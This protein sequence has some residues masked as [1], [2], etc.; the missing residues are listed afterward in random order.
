MRRSCKTIGGKGNVVILMGELSNEAA[1]KRTEGTKQVM[2][3]NPGIK[4]IR[5]Q[6]GNW[7]AR[8]GKTIMENWLASGDKI[9]AVAS[10]ND[11]MALGAVMVIKAAGKLGKIYV[12]GID[13]SPDALDVHG[14]GRAQHDRV[15]GPG[16]PG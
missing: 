16:R 11:E 14:Q 7:P 12:S 4:V 5:E 2:A 6:T 3:K 1:I 13:G 8:R 15:P 10:N 9:D